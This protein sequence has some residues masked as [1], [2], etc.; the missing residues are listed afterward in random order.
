MSGDMSQAAVSAAWP[1]GL[2]FVPSNMALSSV[3][4]LD[5]N[6]AGGN[7]RLKSSSNYISGGA[8]HA[9]DGLDVGIDANKLEAAQGKVTLIGVPEAHLGSTSAVVAFVAP[10]SMGCPVDYSTSD[11]SVI[12]SFT[13]A[14]DSGG[15]RPRN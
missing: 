1:G 5:F 7:Y 15:A 11:P 4:W 3:G 13:R 8:Q 6:H 12:T 9:G 14:S 2:N 10:D